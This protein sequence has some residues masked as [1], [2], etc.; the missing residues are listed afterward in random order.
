[1]EWED[2]RFGSNEAGKAL[3]N[4]GPSEV[5]DGPG[6][7][8]ESFM[9]GIEWKSSGVGSRYT[10][11]KSLLVKRGER[12]RAFYLIPYRDQNQQTQSLE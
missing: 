6:I 1:V 5:A 3:D 2:I 7:S 11:N 10:S 9:N 12:K 8:N 4:C